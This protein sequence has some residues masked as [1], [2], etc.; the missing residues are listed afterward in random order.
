M[1]DVAA[2]LKKPEAPSNEGD[3]VSSFM[4]WWRASMNAA[5][6]SGQPTPMTYEEVMAAAPVRRSNAGYADA[7][8]D[9]DSSGD[10]GDL[11]S[12][13]LQRLS[14]ADNDDS[15]DLDKVIALHHDL[16]G[17]EES[18]RRTDESM[19][20]ET[21]CGAPGA[22]RVPREDV[23]DNLH[24]AEQ[25]GHPGGGAATAVVGGGGGRMIPTAV[26]RG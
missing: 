13:P 6:S 19:I 24:D 2:T 12:P 26:G 4:A 3:V 16:K 7:L 21:T 15:G 1:A 9:E 23:A 14:E 20:P 8:D 25:P 22:S 11:L 10:E 17:V 5:E 18:K